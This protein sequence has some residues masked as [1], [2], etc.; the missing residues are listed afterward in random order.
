MRDDT[1]HTGNVAG[2]PPDGPSLLVKRA[3]D[4]AALWHRTHRRKYPGLDVPYMSHPAGVAAILARHGFDN[5]IVAAGA[6][7][8]V[9]EDARVAHAELAARFGGRVADLVRDCSE[10]DKA[11]SWEVRKARALAHFRRKGWAAQAITL[12]DK[13]D[14]IQSILVCAADLG[15]PWRMFTRGRA[16]QLR[17]L[18]DLA[19]ACGRLAAH[20]LIGEFRAALAALRDVP[21]T[22]G[23]AG[24]PGRRARRARGGAR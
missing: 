4:W 22:G 3:L 11:K 13:I 23:R 8:D 10:P 17:R 2:A 24:T 14:N 1:M 15:D 7:H 19:A 16:P 6:L 18:E 9:M 5:T 12:A 20:P 21:E